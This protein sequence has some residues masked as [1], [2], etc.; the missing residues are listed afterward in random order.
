MCT[1][2]VVPAYR[3]GTC[4]QELWDDLR[5]ALSAIAAYAKGLE[6]IVAWDGPCE[7]GDLPR[8]PRCRVLRRPDG[9]TSPQAHAWAVA[10]TDAQD[11]IGVSDDVVLHPDSVATLLEDVALIRSRGYDPGFVACRSNFAPGPQN[12]RSANGGTWA[13]SVMG[14]SSEATILLA[15]RVSPFCAYISRRATDVVGDVGVEWFSDDLACFDLA[16]QG[17]TN[18]VSRA[19]V[20]HVGMRSSADGLDAGER[21]NREAQDWLALNRPD[22]LAHLLATRRIATAPAVAA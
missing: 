21:L 10:Q 18:W 17:F 11:F 9:L 4:G 15:D 8:N 3:R 13:G 14:Y 7:P 5:V 1:T 2:I 16:R 22:F 19:Y 12:V 6:V 20:H